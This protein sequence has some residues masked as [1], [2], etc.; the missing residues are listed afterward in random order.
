MTTQAFVSWHAS[1]A[2]LTERHADVPSSDAE[3]ASPPPFAIEESINRR[4]VLVRASE[5]WTLAV[6]ALVVGNNEALTDRTGV[7]G[8]IF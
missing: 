3:G 5:P 4:I 8:D 7:V 2:G 6:D 1:L